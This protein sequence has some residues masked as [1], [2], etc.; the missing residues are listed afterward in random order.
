MMLILGPPGIAGL[1]SAGISGSEKLSIIK[2]Y[3]F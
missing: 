1:L 3:G 2:A